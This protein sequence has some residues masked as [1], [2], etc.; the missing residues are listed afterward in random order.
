M[1]DKAFIYILVSKQ[2]YISYEIKII[3]FQIIKITNNKSFPTECN[4]S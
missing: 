4:T 3:L 1:G 2:K